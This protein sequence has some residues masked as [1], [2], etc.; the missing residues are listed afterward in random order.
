MRDYS[1]LFF[2]LTVC[3]SELAICYFY[4]RL[5]QIIWIH[6]FILQLF[7]T[8]LG[9]IQ[10]SEQEFKSFQLIHISLFYA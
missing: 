4:S 2:M 10:P 1:M 6:I 3:I 7:K 8:I 5:N 9:A